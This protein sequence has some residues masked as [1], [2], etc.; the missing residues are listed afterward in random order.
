MHDESYCSLSETGEIRC[1]EV[2]SPFVRSVFNV[3]MEEV[4]SISG[5]CRISRFR[6]SARVKSSQEDCLPAKILM[7]SGFSGRNN[8]LIQIVVDR[9]N[10]L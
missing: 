3:M 7:V 8:P 10:L 1:S 5:I 9:W 2:R 6:R 4:G